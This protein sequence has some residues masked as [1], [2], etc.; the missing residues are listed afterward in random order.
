MLCRIIVI[1]LSLDVHSDTMPEGTPHFWNGFAV[2]TPV[3]TQLLQPAL[4]LLRG[5][6]LIHS[7]FFSLIVFIIDIR[8]NA[9]EI[10]MQ[11]IH[12]IIHDI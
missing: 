8:Q 4:L 5:A 6:F 2:S 11:C 10:T 3:S 7:S 1:I 9:D 12:N